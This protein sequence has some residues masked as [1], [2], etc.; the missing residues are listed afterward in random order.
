MADFSFELDAYER[1]VSARLG[2][3]EARAA[4][5]E[6]ASHLVADYEARLELGVDPETARAA[7]LVSLGDPVRIARAEPPDLR[8][9]AL[10]LA[11]SLFLLTYLLQAMAVQHSSI[12]FSDL[13]I[14]RP[15]VLVAAPALLSIV[16]AVYGS[17]GRERPRWRPLLTGWLVAFAA[18][19]TLMILS[20]SGRRLDSIETLGTIGLWLGAPAIL[21]HLAA[22]LLAPIAA[23]ETEPPGAFALRLLAWP[24]GMFIVGHARVLSPLVP[25]AWPLTGFLLTLGMIGRRRLDIPAAAGATV[26]GLLVNG[27]LGGILAGYLPNP[28]DMMVRDPLK[29]AML[30]FLQAALLGFW[31]LLRSDPFRRSRA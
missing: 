18:L 4:R 2:P 20:G 21:A 1:E 27:S 9:Q 19:P 15:N 17:R 10:R 8:D 31:S 12:R 25:W 24:L 26:L 11:P 14:L 5:L 13:S 30:V 28:I 23:R 7:S 6:L 3:Q 29:F 22:L 16:A